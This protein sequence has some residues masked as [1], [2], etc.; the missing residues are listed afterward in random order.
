MSWILAAINTPA[1]VSETARGL[2][3]QTPSSLF[4]SRSESHFIAAGGIPET[5]HY[6]QDQEAKNGWIVVGLGLQLQLA[7]HSCTTLSQS[8]WQHILTQDVP[9]LP[10]DGHFALIKWQHGKMEAFTDTLGTRTLYYATIGEGI[11]VST[12]LDWVTQ[13]AGTHEID[14]SNFGSHWLAFNQ[15]DFAPLIKNTGRLGSK[16]HLQFERGHSTA[17][18]TPWSPDTDQLQKPGLKQVLEAFTNPVLPQPLT[19]SLGLSGGLDSRTLLALVNQPSTTSLH[20]FGSIEK[21]DVRIAIDIAKSVD[22]PHVLLYEDVP[23][24]DECLQLLQHQVAQT[25][26]MT[27]ASAVLGLRYYNVLRKNNRA[28]ID[29]G[30]GEAARRQFMN[31]LLRQ[32]KSVLQQ[33]NFEAILPFIATPRAG[34]FNPDTQKRMEAG[35]ARQFEQAWQEL[36]PHSAFGLENALDLLSTRSRLPNFFGFEQN[37]LDGLILNYMPFAQPSVLDAVFNTPV[38]SRKEGR[39]FKQMIKS[40]LTTLT[41]FQLVKGAYQYP[42]RLSS[43]GAYIW[44]KIKAKIKPVQPDSLQH[45]FLEAM[46][47]FALDTLSSAAT[48][49]YAP[50][51]YRIIRR[52]V[53]GYYAGEKQLALYVD[54][55]LSFEVWRQQLQNQSQASLL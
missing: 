19:V 24:P 38:N 21:A 9:P 49:T 37:R 8:D 10:K 1:N 20:T 12:R 14:F 42:F 26:A 7:S 30:F 50:Y 18:H 33:Q 47:P 41:D 39:Q 28:V 16:G 45:L 32:G 46:R 6:H 17:Q 4:E 55:W 27:N 35:V 52:N 48:K 40:R 5:C 36:P 22:L 54:W 51:D 31:R 53:E 2:V 3:S 15:L 44:T 23:G 34:L 13:L 11:I 25:Q 29:G 43:T